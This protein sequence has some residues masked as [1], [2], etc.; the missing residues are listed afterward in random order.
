MIFRLSARHNTVTDTITVHVSAGEDPAQLEPVGV[1]RFE[2]P[3]H[4]KTWSTWMRLAAAT[5]AMT[6]TDAIAGIKLE[7]YINGDSE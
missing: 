3:E 4:W 7:L 6:R 2:N 1:L 5:F